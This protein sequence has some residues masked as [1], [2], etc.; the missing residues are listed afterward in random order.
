MGY[1]QRVQLLS[2]THHVF[3]ATLTYNSDSLPYFTC[4]SGI[5]IPYADIK[6]VQNMIK[7][8]RF[9]NSFTRPFKYMAVSERGSFKSRPHFHI[10]F[11]LPM[12]SSDT[13]EI[14]QSLEKHLYSVV[15]SEWK[16]NYGSRRNPIYKPLFTYRE[17]YVHGVLKRNFDF[18]YVKPVVGFSS[19][20]V[21]WYCI[22]YMLKPSTKEHRLQQALHLNLSEDEYNKIW[23]LVRSRVFFSKHFGDS[24]EFVSRIRR[25]IDISKSAGSPFPC[26]YTSD[27]KS[28]P[29]SR[30]YK[31]KARFYNLDDALAFKHNSAITSQ[32]MSIIS[33]P[34]SL[35]ELLQHEHILVKRSAVADKDSFKNEDL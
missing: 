5:D 28:F 13:P 20:S 9:D 17:R 16:R 4:S 32:D 26:F 30:Y 8:I 6:D 11:F 35:S 7:R 3:F 29:L 25:G 15:F 19:D 14:I 31:S 34:R 1:I 27:G 24:P 10:L 22:K 23:N 33:D 18:H 12:F 21:A 2:T